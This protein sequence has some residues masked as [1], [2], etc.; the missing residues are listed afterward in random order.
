MS[1]WPNI[2]FIVRIKMR[3]FNASQLFLNYSLFLYQPHRPSVSFFICADKRLQLN[4]FFV[5]RYSIIIDHSATGPH[6]KLFIKSVQVHDEEIYNCAIIYLKP[7][8]SCNSTGS[9][10]IKLNVL[11]MYLTS[12]ANSSKFPAKLALLIYNQKFQYTKWA[13]TH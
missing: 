7:S 4:H 8:D 12:T 11:G 1:L 9:H 10:K 5:D 3:T 2:W 6:S 13:Y